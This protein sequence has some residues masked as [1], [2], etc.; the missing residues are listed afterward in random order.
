VGE[1]TRGWFIIIII[2]EQRCGQ[3]YQILLD[4]FKQRIGHAGVANVEVGG[5]HPAIL[6]RP[7]DHESAGSDPL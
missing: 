3:H 6:T 5:S 1:S 2:I 4:M 7:S